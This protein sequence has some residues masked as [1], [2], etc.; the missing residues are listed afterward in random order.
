MRDGKAFGEQ[1]VG[2]VKSFMEKALDPIAARL[3]ALEKRLEGSS[4]P[5]DIS[6]EFAALKSAVEGIVI[7]DAPVLPD[8][9]GMVAGAVEKAVAALPMPQNGK[10]ADMNEVRELVASEI[11]S[12]RALVEA[13][14]PAPELPELPDFAAMVD[15][16]VNK[17]VSAIPAPQ[18][19][20]SVTVDDVAPLIA[21]EVQKRVSELPLAKDGEPGKDGIG[22]AGSLI[23]RDGNLVITLTNGEAKQLGPVVGKDAEPAKPGVDGLGFDDLDVIHDG[24]RS[25]TLKFSQGDR[26]KTFPFTLPVVLDKGV[27]KDGQEYEPGDGVTWGGSFWIAQEKTAE[28]PDGGQGWRLAVKRGRDGKDKTEKAEPSKDPI[29]VGVP[30]KAG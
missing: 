23:D 4:A 24:A 12:I 22:L 5:D 20:K 1:V 17:A 29:R 30:A 8:I 11:G 16:A 19:G 25:F 21:S 6:A 27:F 26:V 15:D 10:D 13:I 7:P 9:A 14:E 28:K 18:E 3:D 2:I